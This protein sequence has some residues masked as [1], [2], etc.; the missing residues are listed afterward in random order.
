MSVQ[1]F[2]PELWEESL[3][4]KFTEQSVIG[5]M[6]TAPTEMNGEK[7][8]WNALAPS[9]WKDYVKNQRIDWEQLS[10]TGITATFDRQQMFA[11][12]LD[13]VDKVQLGKNSAKV[14]NSV[15]TQQGNILGEQIDIEVINYM[16]AN[17]TEENTIGTVEKPIQL[18]NANTYDT[19]VDMGVTMSQNKVP[20]ANRFVTINNKILALLAK[21]ERFTR[22][23]DV[24]E[25]GIVQG[26]K[27]NGAT[28]VVKEGLTP[29]KILLNHKSACG[30]GIQLNNME[31][32]DLADYFGD[33]IKG[34]ASWTKKQLRKESSVVANITF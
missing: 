2:K 18:T 4:L 32:V 33:G 25:N 14:I 26:A 3:L 17:T 27:I 8:T 22:N 9:Q 30:F 15:M 23:Y 31:A 11:A 12:I 19:I 20:L 10:T 5:T 28:L 13:D 6:T 7:V 21:D 16:I 29:N 34:L 1:S 24:L